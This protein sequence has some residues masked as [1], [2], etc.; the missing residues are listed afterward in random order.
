MKG[1]RK[2]VCFLTDFSQDVYVAQMKAVILSIYP[3]VNFI[4][5]STKITPQNVL[6]ASFILYHTYHYFPAGTLFVNVVDPG[7]GTKRKI[8]FAQVSDYY[9]LA[10]DNGLLYPLIENKINVKLIEVKNSKFFLKRTSNTFHGRDIFSPVAAYFLKG[11]EMQR[12]GPPLKKIKSLDIF[13]IKK[14]ANF[15]EGKVCFIDN[16]GNIITNIK[17]E[18]FNSFIGNKSFK[19]I[20]KNKIINYFSSTYQ[21][22]P[23]GKPFLIIGSF[24]TVEISLK[25]DSAQKFF[26]ANVGDS[27]K[28]C[29]I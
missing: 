17:E 4:E 19:A 21:F 24:Y 1:R 5:L 7:V 15:I 3:Y 8:I 18:I 6:E 25:N 29:R 16:F 13:A 9:F 12:F 27:V 11:I 26:K 28:I 23:S 20:L 22:A 2:I 14:G 10:P